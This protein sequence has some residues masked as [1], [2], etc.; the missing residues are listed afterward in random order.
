MAA[1]FQVTDTLFGQFFAWLERNVCNALVPVF[2]VPACT[3]S[4]Y[5]PLRKTSACSRIVKGPA[6]IYNESA[7]EA[8]AE[9]TGIDHCPSIAQTNAFSPP[10]TAGSDYAAVV[11]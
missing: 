9:A 11:M 3:K 4:K 5:S 10:D 1:G 2:G 8:C 6:R 7:V